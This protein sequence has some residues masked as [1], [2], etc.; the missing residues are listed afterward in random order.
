MAQLKFFLSPSCLC[1]KMIL[2][3][4]LHI[5]KRCTMNIN[6]NDEKEKDI[7]RYTHNI[8]FISLL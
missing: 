4:N 2:K 1:L 7:L 8:S 5:A 6:H 3:N